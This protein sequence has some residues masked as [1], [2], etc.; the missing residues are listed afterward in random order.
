MIRKLLFGKYYMAA[1]AAFD[2]TMPPD[3]IAVV[4]SYCVA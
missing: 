3:V 1:L 4:V 2:D